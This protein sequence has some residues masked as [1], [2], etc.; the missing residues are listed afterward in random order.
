[1][2]RISSI[3]NKTYPDDLRTAKAS[4]KSPPHEEPSI[5]ISLAKPI[6]TP[7]AGK[8]PGPRDY[9]AERETAWSHTTDRVVDL[10]VSRQDQTLGDEYIKLAQAMILCTL[11]HSATKE[12]KITRRARLG[13]GS[14]L[15]VTFSATADGI[16]LPYGADRKLL[17]WLLDRAIR[18]DSPFVPW[19]SAAEFCREMG[20]EKG[21]RTNKQIK[22]RFSR[23]AGLVISI[24]RKGAEATA[25]DTFPVIA[26]AY[27]PN[28]IAGDSAQASLPELGDRFG[29]LL[30]APLFADIKRHNIV[31]PRR[32]WLELKGPTPVQ[33]L[34]FWLY[35]RCY[36]AV[37]ETIIPWEALTEQFPQSDSNPYRIRQHLRKAIKVLKVLWPEVQVREDPKGLWVARA[38]AGMLD[39]DS[40]KNRVRKL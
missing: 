26:R 36:A 12:I 9:S 24:S 17:F 21:G 40:T 8:R 10:A 22:E 32:L 30:H 11:P 35:Y 2:E 20:L 19:S 15:A 27:L 5:S 38:K 6:K 39:D 1:M 28:S 3:I 34:V 25:L 29:V 18:N 16:G 13:D 33:D 23:I 37:S 7:G 14:T 31:M 4:V